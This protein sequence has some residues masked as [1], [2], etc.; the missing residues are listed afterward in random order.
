MWLSV[1]LYNL[2]EAGIAVLNRDIL[3]VLQVLI[4]ELIPSLLLIRR[5]HQYN[6]SMHNIGVF[7]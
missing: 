4:I 1:Y 5:R 7:F 6:A 3:R 2:I